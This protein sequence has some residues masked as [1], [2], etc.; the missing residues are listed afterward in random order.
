MSEPSFYAFVCIFS[1]LFVLDFD[2]NKIFFILNLVIQ[3]LFFAKSS[4][5]LLYLF[6]FVVLFGIKFLLKLTVR[7][8]M[9]LIALGL[10]AILTYKLLGY[11]LS[12][13]RLYNAL[14]IENP[15]LL[16]SEQSIS[17][18]LEHIVFH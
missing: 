15:I 10:G 16:F 5:G 13:S 14:V 3:I 8:Y 17:D 1:M 6:I 11:F 2:K 9:Y 18:R 4:I 12:H 7:S